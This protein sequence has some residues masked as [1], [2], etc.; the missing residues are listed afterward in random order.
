MKSSLRVSRSESLRGS[1]VRA[2]RRV[3][4][5]LLPLLLAGPA[6]PAAAAGSTTLVISELRTRGPLGAN[7]EFIEIYNLSGGAIDIGGWKLNASS[8]AGAVSLRF[9]F[10]GGTVVASGCHRLV[11]G[12]AYGGLVAG[13]GTLAAGVADDGGVALLTAAD[14][15]VD[16]VGFSVGSAYG[17]ASRL[18]PTPGNVE[19]SYERKPGGAS[20]NGQDTD[21]NFSDFTYVT[22]TSPQNSSSACASIEGIFANGFE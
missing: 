19:Q 13:D 5:V 18:T 14:V 21:D 4:L 22:N 9:T 1:R 17:E 10:A 7:D 16:Q 20:G 8:F 15:V 3:S 6:I 12:S 11:V 2:R